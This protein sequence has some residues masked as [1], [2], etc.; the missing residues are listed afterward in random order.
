MKNIRT[1]NFPF[2]RQLLLGLVLLILTT[3]L[4]LFA[5]SDHLRYAKVLVDL[6]QENILQKMTLAGLPVDHYH[7]ADENH[8]ALILS[9]PEVDIMNAKGFDYSFLIPDM[10]THYARVLQGSGA[11]RQ[12]DCGLTNFDQGDMGGYHTYNQV[13]SHLNQ[14]QSLYPDIITVSTI[15]QS[16]ENRS[17]PAAKISD[18]PSINESSTEAAVYFDALTHCREPMSL[19]ATLY[20]MWW[21]LENYGSDPE[22]TYLVNNRQIYFVPVVNPDGY[23]YNETIEPNGGGLWRKNRREADNNCFGVDLNRNYGTGWGLDS[24]S[25][26]DPCSNIYRGREAFS[27]PESAAVRDFLNSVEPTIGFTSHTFGDKFLSPFGYIDSLVTYELYAEF[28]SEFAPT[29]YDGYGTTAKMLNYTSSGTTR[30]YFHTA[31][32]F[33]WTPEI[34]HEFWEPASVICE[35]VNEFL[36]TMQYLT[37]VSGNYACYHDYELLDGD[38]IWQGDTIA[39]DVRIK[40][41]GLSQVSEDVQVTLR[42]IHP[43]LIPVNNSIAYGNVSPRSFEDNGENPFRFYVQNILMV[44]ERV[45]IQVEVQ[46]SGSISYLD[47]LYLTA[48]DRLLL[49]DK[50]NAESGIGNWSTAG[51]QPWDTSFMDAFSGFKSFAD[52]RYGNYLSNSQTIISFDQIIDLTGTTQPYVEYN[53]KWS[54]EH[55]DDFTYFEISLNG[56]PIWIP[57]PGLHTVTSNGT[58]AYTQNKHWVQER[59]DLSSFIDEPEVRVRFRLLADGSVHSDGFYFDDFRVV[60]YSEPIIIDTEEALK[61]LQDFQ[62][63]PNPTNQNAWVQFQSLRAAQGQIRLFNLLGQEVYSEIIDGQLG[64]NRYLIDLEALSGGTY[65]LLLEY[66]EEHRMEKL[67]KS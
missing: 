21:L 42:S 31:G 38:R 47:T 53:A 35:R 57:L 16:I 10:K 30:D 52:S 66:G 12:S 3:P 29:N 13:I 61:N 24:G 27:E 15:G 43:A 23:V 11:Q 55:F 64:V 18:N 37:W 9:Y 60:D 45:P 17:I 34:G 65:W 67:V 58:P 5:Q 46:Q 44:G 51:T 49:T 28:S 32:V 50:D 19:E 33:A 1:L 59:I 40:N 6:R 36:P 22:A 63:F 2:L 39:L 20:Y 54:L 7:K 14:M 56:S 62:V 25:S 26:N 4:V 41:R 8:I 48:G